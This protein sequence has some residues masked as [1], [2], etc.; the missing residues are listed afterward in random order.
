MQKLLI[1]LLLLVSWVEAQRIVVLS[2]AI[3]EIVFA[4]G[5]G[6]EIVGNTTYCTYPKASLKIAKVGGYFSPSLERILA[7]EPDVVI[8]QHNNYRLKAKLERLGIKTQVI[9]IDTLAHIKEAFIAIAKILDEQ[10]LA[11]KFIQKINNALQSLKGITTNKRI[12]FVFGHNTS[13]NSR[14]FVAGQ[15][16]YFNEI[17]EYSGNINALQSKRKGQPVLNAENIIA[18]Q[19][20]IVVLLAHSMKEKHLSADDLIAPWKTLPIPAAKTN[21]IYI[22]DKKYASIPSDRLVLFIEDFRAI[23]DEYASHH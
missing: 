12:L 3:N 23:L 15:N 11:Q 16:L 18:T 19:P 21:A 6:D 10:P 4:L 14:I 17:I 13:L 22:I 20:D 9:Q 7:L 2:P 5:H 8:M 1:F